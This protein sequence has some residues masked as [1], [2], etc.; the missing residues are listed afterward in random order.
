VGFYNLFN[1]NDRRCI[2]LGKANCP[3][4]GGGAFGERD[5]RKNSGGHRQVGENER[6]PSW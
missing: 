5:V 3:N 4:E 1:K 2:G 6:D